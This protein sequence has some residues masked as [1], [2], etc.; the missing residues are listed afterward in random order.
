MSELLY[1][2]LRLNHTEGDVLYP[3]R[4]KNMD[5]GRVAFRL[6]KRG[7]TKADSI[8]VTDEQEMIRKVTTQGY[9]VRARTIKPVSKGG[10]GGL[11]SLT[12][13]SIRDWQ[14]MNTEESNA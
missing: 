5:T 8:E 1:R 9:K 12:E 14:L 3:A 10:R 11:Y 6:S 2:K 13:T 4:M 7:N